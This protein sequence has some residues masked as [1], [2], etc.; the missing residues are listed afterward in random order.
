MPNSWLSPARQK[1]NLGV[2]LLGDAY[3]M[4]HP[5][6]GG[7]MTVAFNDV[8]I[9]SELL[10]PD[11]V[12][13][14]GNTNAINAAMNK[15]HWQRKLLTSIINVLVMALYMLFAAQGRQLAALQRGCFVYKK[16]LTDEPC[17]MLGSSLHQPCVLA[18]H[19]FAVTFLSIGINAIDVCGGSIA[20]I[21]KVPMAALDTVLILYKA[22]LPFCPLCGRNCSNCYSRNELIC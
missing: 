7:G 4:R 18:Y 5:L 8:V 10:H 21:N 1:G 19:F 6:T 14:F 22:A 9:L 15:F 17:A 16:G 13:D 3:N 12:A 11:K 2:V 20:G